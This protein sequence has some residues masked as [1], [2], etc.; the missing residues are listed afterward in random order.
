MTKNE[1]ILVSACLLGINC[2]YKGSNK[3]SDKV[4]NYIKNKNFIPICPEVFGG[5]STPRPDAEIVGGQG[6][7]VLLGETK[8]VEQNNNDVTD[9]FITGAK[10]ILRIA[11]LT[12]ANK[13]IL[14]ARSPSCGVNETYDGSF[15]RKI[16]KG[17]GVLSALLKQNKIEVISDED[18]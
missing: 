2:N 12:G 15:S 6:Q 1:T 5:F 8:V 17:D 4:L 9:K 16:I 14:K 13:A 18:L 11:E 10:E 3:K 7:E